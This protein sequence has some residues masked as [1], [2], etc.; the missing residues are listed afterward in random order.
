MPY[1]FQT[2]FYRTAEEMCRAIASACLSPGSLKDRER[3]LAVL[4]DGTD[5]ELADDAIEGLGLDCRQDH[6]TWM[7][8]RG[9]TRE[10]IMRAFAYLRAYISSPDSGV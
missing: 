10:D 5:E 8:E 7:E 1:Q 9:V 6:A 4:A 3:M 2:K